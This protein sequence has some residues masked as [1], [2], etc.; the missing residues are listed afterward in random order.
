MNNSIAEIK[1]RFLLI[2][3]SDTKKNY[4]FEVRNRKLRHLKFHFDNKQCFVRT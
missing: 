2:Q 4:A 3:E 1:R